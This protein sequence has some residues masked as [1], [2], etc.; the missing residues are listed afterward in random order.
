M[1][2]SCG[3]RFFLIRPGLTPVAKFY[4]LAGAP[5]EALIE[6][7]DEV[8]V[9]TFE[10][11]EV[12]TEGVDWGAAGLR[13]P[14][15]TWTYLVNNNVFGGNAFLTLSPRASFGFL[16]VLLLWPVMLLWAAGEKWQRWRKARERREY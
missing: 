3:W 7:I 15:S 12:T 4:R 2:G 5:F 11:L 16:G 9:E 8:V 1:G 13:A 10:A 6:R 14:S